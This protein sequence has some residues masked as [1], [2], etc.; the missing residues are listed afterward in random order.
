MAQATTAGGQATSG[1]AAQ[2]MHG[3]LARALFATIGWQ[4]EWARDERKWTLEFMAEL[5]AR[6]AALPEERKAQL[7]IDADWLR[8]AKQI[9]GN[10]NS[11][12]IG[13]GRQE[14]IGAQGMFRSSDVAETPA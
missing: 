12:G 7:Q 9:L 4:E 14:L 6:Y 2:D 13:P 1:K 5:S 11:L 8:I 10:G 3:P